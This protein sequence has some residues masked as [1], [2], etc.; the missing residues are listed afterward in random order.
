[1]KRIVFDF[2]RRWAWLYAAG[3]LVATGLDV[4]ALFVP[5]FGA[6][7]PYFLAPMLGPLFVLGMD[8]MRGAGGVTIALPVSARRIGI[9]YWLVGVCAPAM[10]LSLALIS[11]MIIAPLLRPPITSGWEQ[12]AW[13]FVISLLICGSIFFVLTCVKTGPQEGLWNNVGAGLAGALWGLSAFSSIGLKFLLDS[14]KADAVTMATLAFAA[15]VLTVLG[16][17]H[18]GAMVRSR[19]R[20]R[21][22]RRSSPRTVAT[23]EAVS[24][25]SRLSGFPYLF[26]ESLK[27]TLGMAA[28]MILIGALLHALLRVNSMFVLYTLL[29]C[30]LL[31]SLRFLTGLRQIRTLPIS[32]NGLAFTLF[33]LPML[34]FALCLTLLALVKTITATGAFDVTPAAVLFSAAI[35]SLANAVLVR[36]GPKLLPFA[37]VVCVMAIFATPIELFRFPSVAYYAVSAALMIAAFMLLRFSLRC[38]NIYR[39]PVVGYP[40]G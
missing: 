15:L 36:F 6:F 39:L 11:A 27:F 24:T 25:Q 20:I 28:V 29:L 4:I 37:F 22:V 40:V 3:F 8:L 31:P 23:A 14:R 26:V 10:L 9:A 19:A 2:L 35:A 17:L 5:S 12:V 18:G 32:L 13:T 33:L 1:M 34:N 30:A 16:F 21:A 38:S 7:T